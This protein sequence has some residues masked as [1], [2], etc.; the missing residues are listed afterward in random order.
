MTMITQDVYP[1]LAAGML[2]AERCIV[3]LQRGREILLTAGAY[4]RAVILVETLTADQLAA[5]RRSGPLAL[6][7]TG[8]RATVLGRR[9]DFRTALLQLDGDVTLSQVRELAGLSNL[10]SPLPS[11][12]QWQSEDAS[13]ALAA[14]QL[15]RHAHAL[16]A[17]LVYAT[18]LAAETAM[19]V[20]ID[21]ARQYAKDTGAL[22]ALSRTRIPLL[23]A[24]SVELAVF[25]ERHGMAEHVAITVGEPD[26]RAPVTVRL[27][28]SCFTGDILGSMRCDCGEQLSGA[29]ASMASTG[30]GVVLY[31][32]QEGRGIGLA[33][34][35]RAY[36]LQD[37]GLDTIEANQHLGF[38]ADD[39]NYSAASRMLK[40][41]GIGRIRLMTNNPLKIDA[42]RE[43]GIDVVDRL[44]SHA[45][46]NAH[47]ARYLRTKRERAGHLCAV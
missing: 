42:L 12:H 32:S 45:T 13:A 3:E 38:G 30:G 20:S 46:V 17:L 43:A 21:D 28:S 15:A 25:R 44:P 19:S 29:I 47:N 2:A 10:Q 6:A 39:R 8:Q 5:I 16:P 9:P 41:L 36:Q 34:K 26:K 37:D 11:A 4:R 7:L 33:S 31:V 14:L 1:Q 22:M 18:P 40:H 35:L 27:H 23:S 24:A